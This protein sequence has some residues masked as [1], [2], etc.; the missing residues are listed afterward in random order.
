MIE[1]EYREFIKN[2]A[3]WRMQLKPLWI[4]C[5]GKD[6][7]GVAESILISKIEELRHLKLGK[8]YDEEEGDL[9]DDIKDDDRCEVDNEQL[10]GVYDKL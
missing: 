7:W 2:C 10:A 1:R 3:E 6:G 4:V 9:E 8:E 5:G